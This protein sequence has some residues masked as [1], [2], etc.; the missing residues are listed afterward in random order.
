MFVKIEPDYDA[1]SLRAARVVA[2]LVRRKPNAVLG[3]ATGS[4]PEGLYAHLIR[5]ARDEKLDFSRVTTF[6]LDE[7]EGLPASHPESYRSFMQRHLFDALGLSTEQTNIL[8]GMSSDSATEC[9]NF[10]AKIR[11]AGG[12]D[13]QILGIGGDGRIA[14]CEPS[15]S[16]AGRTSLVALHPQTIAD[17]ARFFDRE[18]DVPRKALTMGV[19]TILEARSCLILA[20]GKAKADVWAKMIEGPITSQLPASAL[21]LHPWVIAIADTVAASQLQHGDYYKHMDR[22]LADQPVLPHWVFQPE[23]D[24][25]RASLA[26]R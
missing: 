23:L 24:P 25:R 13:L 12:I 16:L 20:K 21:Q 17:N 14:F 8:S 15:A 5:I 26:V 19:G 2:Q 7:Y 10:E 6:N 22:E 9:A 3:L 18:E 4:T 11:H 1:L